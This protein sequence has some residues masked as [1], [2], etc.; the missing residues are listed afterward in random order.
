MKLTICICAYNAERYLTETLDSLFRQTFRDF[1]L[2]IIDDASTDGTR[3]LAEHYF[4]E[5]QWENTQ[6]T[7][8]PQNGGLARARH[9]AEAHVKT[10]FMG[11]IDADDVAKPD[12]IKKMFSY[13]VDHPDCMVVSSYCE[14]ISAESKKI[15][16]GVFLGPTTP[17]KFFEMAKNQKLMFVPAFNISRVEY[18][19]RAGCHAI[20]GFPSGKVRYQDMCEDL[21]LWTRMSDFYASGKYIIVLPEILLSYRR[22]MTSVSANTGAM[23]S[24]IRQIKANLLR[25]RAGLPELSYVDYISG[26]S[27]FQRIRYSYSDWSS[28]LYK[29]AGFHYLNRHY[30]RFP[31]CLCAGILFNPGYFIQKVKKNIIPALKKH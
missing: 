3:T 8:L 6:V 27:L 14:Y 18:I 30:L 12:A 2:W 26:L 25:R 7:T 20:D 17:E 16:G 11:F 10:E 21:D 13:I 19:R 15:P 1:S 23:L 4:T 29:R 24:R 28:G 5:H 9:Y 22:I 31:F